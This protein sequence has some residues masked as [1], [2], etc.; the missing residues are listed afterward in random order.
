MGVHVLELGGVDHGA[1]DA[2]AQVAPAAAGDDAAE[3]GAEAASHPGLQRE[4]GGLGALGAER[5]NG[6]EHRRG[7]AGVHG[8]VG[9]AL[10]LE[11][12]QLGDKSAAAHGAVVGGH[13]RVSQQR[14]SRGVPAVAEAEQHGG[15]AS[16][17]IASFEGPAPQ[18]RI[19]PDRERRDPGA[20]THEDRAARIGGRGEADTERP[21]QPHLLPSAQLA[22]PARAGP[23]VLE[24]EVR[25]PPGGEAGEGEG[26]RQM[27][28]LVLPPPQRSAAASIANWPG[29]G[30]GPWGSAKRSTL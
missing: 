18:E 8:R 19:L 23:D 2:H 1:L 27:G 30:V 25:L 3:A 21:Q 5:A 28:A 29:S 13:A 17:A 4:L 22:Q 16:S 24:Q 9:V 6:L 26:A 20:A 11:R 7:A 12:E 15:S 10:E 14:G